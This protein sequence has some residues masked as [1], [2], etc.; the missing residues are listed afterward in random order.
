MNTS[1]FAK[2]KFIERPVSISGRA[3]EF[4]RGP[5]F[6]IL[7]PKLW[8]FQLYKE[9]KIGPEE[10]TECYNEE[11]LK[12]LDQ[13]TI[14]DKLVDIYKTE[15]LT[16][17]CYEKPGDFCH[18]HLVAKWFTEAGYLVEEKSF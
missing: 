17:L 3:P 5:Q 16:L 6:K 15:D 4:Y 18:R 9:G 1:Y 13:K 8:F 14:F 11:V 10:Y 7:A 12:D 2:L